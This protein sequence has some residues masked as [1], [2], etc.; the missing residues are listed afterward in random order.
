V[1]SLALLITANF[2]IGCK[3][4]AYHYNLV[5]KLVLISSASHVASMAFVHQYF[6]RSRALGIVRG[7]LIFA[8]HVMGWD[9]IG[10]RAWSPIF[11]TAEPKTN[12]RNSNGQYETSLVLPASCFIEHTGIEN[13]G[14][15]ASNS[16][17]NFTASQYWISNITT[18]PTA[19]SSVS[20]NGTNESTY[21]KG[22]IFQNFNNNDALSNDDMWFYIAIAVALCFTFTASVI[23]HHKKRSTNPLIWRWVAYVLRCLSFIII[24][25]VML[26]ALIT[27][28]SLQNWMVKSGWFGK[29]DGERS[30]ESF[31]QMMPLVLL[32][33][34]FLALLEEK[35]SKSHPLSVGEFCRIPIFIFQSRTQLISLAFQ[36]QTRHPS[37]IRILRKA[38]LTTAVRKRIETRS[39]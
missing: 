29:D 1:T 3:I 10:R 11:P 24:Y 20:S 13:P 39:D 30:F 26:N 16:Y 4:S 32:F 28:I 37:K 25:V 8:S 22:S 21:T 15:S 34:P 38:G 33:L 19:N 9:L 6:E 27:F 5:C 2:T 23:L 36:L 7:G 14:V 31:G 35:S 12:I 18:H 17:G